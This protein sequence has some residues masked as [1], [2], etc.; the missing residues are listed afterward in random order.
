MADPSFPAVTLILLPGPRL[1]GVHQ[2][3]TM[4]SRVER[5]GGGRASAGG[6][7]KDARRPN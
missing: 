5:R 1:Q 2:Q 6:M 7:V 3:R 4:A